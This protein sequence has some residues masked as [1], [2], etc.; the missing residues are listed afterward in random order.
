MN[1]KKS[2]STPNGII[3]QLDVFKG[4][5]ALVGDYFKFSYANTVNVL[6]SLGFDV[7]V[8]ETM[9]EIITKI[10]NGNKYDVIFTNNIYKYGG[11]GY[12]L[13]EKLKS[14]KGFDTPVV[15]HTISDNIDNIFIRQG[16]DGYL[17]KYITQEETL[18]LL[19][20]LLP[21]KKSED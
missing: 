6:E 1:I 4:R 9:Q 21:I 19:T 8:C 17:K 20:S 12:Q 7:E 16:F 14:I 18:K 10:L 13:L 11:Y 2:Y 15:I 5:R 3:Y